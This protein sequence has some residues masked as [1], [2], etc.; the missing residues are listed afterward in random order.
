MEKVDKTSLLS[1]VMIA[2]GLIVNLQSGNKYIGS[3][4]FSLALLTIINRGLQLY[5]GRIGFAIDNRHSA[6]GYL[7]MLLL[8]FAGSSVF[9]IW[10]LLADDETQQTI[11]DLSKAKFAHSY[12]QLFLYGVLC[13][14]L[15]FIAVSCKETVITIFCIMTFILS[16]FEHCIADFPYFVVGTM[17]AEKLIKFQLIVIGNSLGSIATNLLMKKRKPKDETPCQTGFWY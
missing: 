11:L 8:N 14:V 17:T 5:T 1:G 4:L 2:I 12:E 3:M 9:L 7:A 10:Y 16:G 6:Q 15:M 13:G